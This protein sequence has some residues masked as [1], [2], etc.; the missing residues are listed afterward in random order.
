M[1]NY[2]AALYCVGIGPCNPSCPG[3]YTSWE[4]IRHRRSWP[5]E[6]CGHSR[7]ERSRANTART[8]STRGQCSSLHTPAAFPAP[9]SAL[10]EDPWPFQRCHCLDPLQCSP[11]CPFGSSGVHATGAQEQIPS[12]LSGSLLARVTQ[13]LEK[14]CS[15]TCHFLHLEKPSEWEDA[16]EGFC[17]L[18]QEDPSSEPQLAGK[19]LPREGQTGSK[20]CRAEPQQRG[21]SG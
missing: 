4:Q 13:H 12:D 20:S 2:S 17:S 10:G 9:L 21:S 19:G 6:C 1:L 7:S 11:F 5:V 16:G 14:G 8:R 18:E 3:I 15:S